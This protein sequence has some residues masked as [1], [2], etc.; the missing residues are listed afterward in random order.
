M[1]FF[2]LNNQINFI[3]GRFKFFEA[4]NEYHP[5][6]YKFYKTRIVNLTEEYNCIQSS[7]STSFFRSSYIAG[8]KF[9]E[10]ILCGEDTR[11]VNELLLKIQ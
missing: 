6:D 7:S 4:R 10:G 11:F 3:S 8:K 1:S 2:K 9:P 5:L